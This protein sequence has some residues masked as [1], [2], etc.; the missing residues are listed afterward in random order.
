MTV[1]KREVQYVRK[2]ISK[3][4]HDNQESDYEREREREREKKGKLQ[5]EQRGNLDFVK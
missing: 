1:R 2:A 4:I 5:K 3:N